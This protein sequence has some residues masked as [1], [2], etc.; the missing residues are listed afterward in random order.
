MDISARVNPVLH[1]RRRDAA[2]LCGWDVV[3]VA[4]A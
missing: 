2:A 4:V 1:S 3:R